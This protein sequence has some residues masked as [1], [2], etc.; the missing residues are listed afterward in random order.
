MLFFSP[1]AGAA[2]VVT[3]SFPDALAAALANNLVLKNADI[4]SAQSEIDLR[5]AE[6]RRLPEVDMSGRYARLELPASSDIPIPGVSF[7]ESEADVSLGATMPLYTGGRIASSLRQAKTGS[8]L[9]AE[10]ANRTRGDTL[11]E[12]ATAFLELLAAQQF[13]VIA[14]ESLDSSRRHLRDVR[15]LLEKG[16]VAQVDLF[17][18]ELDEAERE[19]D[20]ASAEANLTRRSEQLA[21]I[22]FPDRFVSLRAEWEVPGPQDL[23][24]V[25]EWFA[26]AAEGSLEI[27]SARLAL[28]LA[29]E[30]VTAARA[31]HRPAFGLFGNYGA[32][33]EDFSY[34]SEDHY[35]NTGL[36]LSFPLYRGG[37][38]ARAVER[39][40]LDEAK[41]RNGLTETRRRVG[42][43]VI[44]RHAAVVLARKQ[45][46]AA[47][48]AVRAGEENLRVTNLK[49]REGLVTN[50]DV[51]D[52][53][54]SLSRSRFDHVQALKE[55]HINR[56]GLMRL[57][58]TIEE[59]L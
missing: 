6:G 32:R 22:I 23:F 39:A 30:Q 17:R 24:S 12:T 26:L 33:G 1:A 5:I 38:T 2:E 53:L 43:G 28:D 13:V 36:N 35:W 21:S 8:E 14:G 52:A 27:S 29:Q 34:T 4:S 55:F 9:S 37:R 45:Y 15:L 56:Y 31:G 20:I 10:A 57:A 42:R 19:R 48:K 25:D 47:V 51:I 18:S 11:L 7:P 46:A 49:Y 16:Q 59:I 54:L 44:E 58:G 40:L 3:L 41:A 50:T